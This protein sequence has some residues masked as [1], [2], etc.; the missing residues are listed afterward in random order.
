MIGSA[1]ALAIRVLRGVA[2]LSVCAYAAHSLVVFG[3]RP[4]N[5]LFE[6]WIFNAL[7]FAGAALC[8]LRGAWCRVE[9]WA[10]IVL[11]VGLACWGSARSSIRSIPAS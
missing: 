8:L 5:G 10:W 4:L 9:R 1:R 3:G 7:F 11:G 6:N 2:L